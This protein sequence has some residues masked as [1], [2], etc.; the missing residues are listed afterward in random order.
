MKK[1]KCGLRMADGGL[2]MG[3]SILAQKDAFNQFGRQ[4]SDMI[5]AAR[6]NM[7]KNTQS[8]MEEL[9]GARMSPGR[10]ARIMA[11][12]GGDLSKMGVTTDLSSFSRGLSPG[13]AAKIGMAQ[14]DIANNVTQF[15]LGQS[16]R[17][18]DMREKNN[19]FDMRYD[20]SLMK[21]LYMAEGGIVR[22]KGG[23]TDDMVPM[24]VNGVDVNLS[25]T[26]AVLPAKT[27]QALGGPEAVEGLIEQTNGKPP[28]KS[29]LRAGGE[30]SRGVVYDELE[31]GQPPA[32]GQPGSAWAAIG[33]AL[34]YSDDRAKIAAANAASLPKPL[35]TP[36][37]T[38]AQSDPSYDRKEFSSAAGNIAAR[39]SVDNPNIA[40]LRTAGVTGPV[41][42]DVTVG[43]RTPTTGI[44]TINTPN[45]AVYAGRDAKGQLVVNSNVNPGGLAAADMARDQEFAAKGYG[46]DAYGNWMTPQRMADKQSLAQIQ[47]DR[48]NFNAFNDQVNDPQARA[49]GLRKVMFDTKQ[50]ELGNKMAVDRSKL[51]LDA[52]KFDQEER[53]IAN[54]QGNSDRE[55]SQ[56]VSEA[57]A[58]RLDDI[59]KAKATKDGKLDGEAYA[60]L[61]EY[62]GNFQSKHKEGTQAYFKDLMDN[63]GVD[64]AF[65]ADEGNWLR[66]V[67][68]QGSDVAQGLR[69]QDGMLWGKYL[70]DPATRRQVSTSDIAKMP[71]SQQRVIVSRI[72]DPQL[73]ATYMK[74]LGLAN[75]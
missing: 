26:E 48:A 24:R 37:A 45:G 63:L 4:K 69:Q 60:R 12:M 29:G 71:P 7:I 38:S 9:A 16:L 6:Q 67:R 13:R 11:D 8:Q 47:S 74:H 27:V 75:Q 65:M 61:Q 31:V 57:N 22:G 51:Q 36:Q 18:L 59:L 72:E 23:P 32:T 54:L 68:R 14:A 53:K 40:G 70:Q 49:A 64:A 42:G 30:Y 3:E 17:S 44:R 25:N 34:R 73:R 1:G 5:D 58:K 21:G 35:T 66:S 55:Y 33:N 15:G 20:D 52:A 2:L 50:Q 10:K 41:M 46:K 62:A 43:G 56:K 19:E 39:Q 28:V